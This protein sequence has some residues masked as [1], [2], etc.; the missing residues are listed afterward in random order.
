MDGVWRQQAKKIS[1]IVKTA[2]PFMFLQ[3]LINQ[4]KF[5][6]AICPSSKKLARQMA[7]HIPLDNDGII[8]ELGGG[9]GVITQAILDHGVSPDKL[10][11]IEFSHTFA[12]HLKTRFPHITVIN[13]NAAHLDTL[14]PHGAKI[15]A[16]VSSLPLISL[17]PDTCQQILQQWHTLL[18][19]QGLA[20]QFT[21]N[22]RSPLWKTHIHASQ[23]HSEIV[24]GNIPP[25]KVMTF[26]F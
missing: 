6:G 21:Y 24:W 3:E 5:T 12:C 26:K 2:G 25:A 10:Y 23:F 8:I 22:L 9:T 1:S 17:P 14:I 18:K 11:V 16:V 7:R 15:N 19:D 4:P 20:I 13:G